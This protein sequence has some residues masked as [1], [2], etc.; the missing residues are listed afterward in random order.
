MVLLSAM[1]A[2]ARAGGDAGA[3]IGS[4]G[5][6]RTKETDTFVDL[7]RR[8]DVGYVAL[9]AANPGVDPWVP[10]ERKIVI[11]AAHLLPDAPHAGIVI[12]IGEMRLYYFDAKSGAVETFPIGVG[13]EAN[14]TPFGTAKVV[15]KVENPT[16]VPTPAIQAEHPELPASIP[17]GPDNPLGAYALYLDW[18]SFRIHGT[19]KPPGVGRRV[20]HG[21]IRLYPEDIA[22]L[23]PRV[24]IGTP[25]TVV[26]QDV[27]IGRVGNQLYL[28]IHPNP[29]QADQ[30][31]QTGKFSPEPI[32]G[33]EGMIRTAAGPEA[34]RVDWA[35]VNETAK[36]RRGIPVQITH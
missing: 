15:K 29:A 9:M 33:L 13:Q 23:Y 5:T 18:D 17:P 10:G 14:D 12:N 7:A 19:N 20:S 27:K 21:C 16:W 11:P 22:A 8:F 6:Y 3:L 36:A 32:D 31:E 1:A 24:A 30:I 4:V 34:G 28:E 25:V 35:L 2:P 26:F